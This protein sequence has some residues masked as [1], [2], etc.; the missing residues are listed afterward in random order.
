M[1]YFAIYSAGNSWTLQRR[2][3]SIVADIYVLIMPTHFIAM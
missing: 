2:N 1:I 3:S